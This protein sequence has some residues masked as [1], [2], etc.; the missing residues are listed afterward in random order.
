MRDDHIEG[1]LSQQVSQ[2]PAG[3]AN[4]ERLADPHLPQLVNGGS[5]GS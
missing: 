3:A 1:L 2:F 4:R 5:S